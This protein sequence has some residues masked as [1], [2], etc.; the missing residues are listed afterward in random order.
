[1]TPLR[2][3][4][5]DPC[6]AA[7][8][9]AYPGPGGAVA[10]VK[11]GE[12][13]AR[14]SWGWANAERRIPFTPRSLFR[15]CSI[16]KQFTCALLLDAFPDP[17]ALD[18]DL[19]AMLPLLEGP[20]PAVLDLCHNQSGLRDYW[21]VAMLQGSPVEAPFGDTEAA[22][23]IGSTRSLHFAP[24][25]RYSYVNQNFRILSDMLEARTGEGFGERLRA[26]IF[27]RAGMESAF[28]AADTR[29]LPDGTEG[30]EGSQATGFRAAVNNILWTGDAGL[31]ACLDD[32]IA[33]ERW[34]DATR[35]DPDG[36]YNRLSAPARFADGRPAE[37]G[38]GLGR[39]TEFGRALTGHGGALRGWRSHRLHLASE[40]LSVVVMFN[41]LSDAHGA[42]LDI[43]AAALGE[44]RPAPAAP[45]P[46]PDWLGAYLEPETG[47]SVRID[48]LPDGAL[49]L[50]YGHSAERLEMQPDGTAGRQRTRLRPGREGLW[51]D[52]PQENQST[53]LRP[54]RGSARPDIAG[55]YRCAELE[56][57]LTM[58]DSGG[59]PYGGFSGFLGQGRM[60]LLDPIGPDLWALPCHRALDHT[61]PGDWTLAFRRDASGRVSGATVGCWL[62]RGLDYTRIG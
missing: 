46:A 14:H 38:F 29:A 18:G 42:A 39:G 53:L 36:L 31:G 22:R 6:L 27:D 1:M 25:T 34:I 30:Y 48:A 28:L 4:R 17:T 33:W 37:Y 56:A 19:R 15:M 35:D 20:A 16:T 5:L 57:E 50:R 11:D 59:I 62:A 44:E 45:P 49:R 32:M 21:A 8:P 61:P 23:L 58:T 41:H 40:R 26:R 52:R 54:A 43:L 9:R 51:M 60:E 7:L 3:T 55:R 10:V 2:S 24:G 13:L 47:L 12:V